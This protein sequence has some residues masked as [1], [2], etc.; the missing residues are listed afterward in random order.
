MLSIVCLFIIGIKEMRNIRVHSKTP[1][2][3]VIT[4][5]AKTGG[6]SMKVAILKAV[7]H[8][9]I[10]D[11]PQICCGEGHLKFGMEEYTEGEAS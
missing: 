8:Y 5:E 7:N 4:L 6:S 3:D 11:T 10:P 2:K 9:F 1:Q